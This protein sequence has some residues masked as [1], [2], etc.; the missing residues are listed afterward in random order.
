M[1][2]YESV[3][4]AVFG[5]LLGLV[6]GLFFAFVVIKALGSENLSFS[7]PFGQIVALMLFAMVVG[8]VAAIF[9]ARRASRLDVL[10]AIAYE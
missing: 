2:R 8:V 3:I 9:P 10:R 5:A 6:L 7:L 1:V 4:T